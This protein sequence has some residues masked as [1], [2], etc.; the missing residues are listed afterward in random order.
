MGLVR[1]FSIEVVTQ[2]TK[3]P[4]DTECMV[5]NISSSS[6]GTRTV[7]IAEINITLALI[8]SRDSNSIQ[9][10]P[11]EGADKSAKWQIVMI[12]TTDTRHT[13]AVDA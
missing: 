6:V 12:V 5:Q 1:T 4:K 3:F 2:E 11:K 8:A 9:K 7:R 13:D 10:N